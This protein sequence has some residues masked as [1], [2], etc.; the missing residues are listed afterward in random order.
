MTNK[1]LARI[2]FVVLKGIG[3][4]ITYMYLQHMQILLEVMQTLLILCL[5]VSKNSTT[6]LSLL[7][8][9]FIAECLSARQLILYQISCS[10]L[11]MY[12]YVYMYVSYLGMQ[13]MRPE[14]YVAHTDSGPCHTFHVASRTPQQ[15]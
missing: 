11:C 2:V 5:K 12:M 9:K 6:S 1:S 8:G 10:S 13:F 15:R 7:L 3:L 14:L 4:M